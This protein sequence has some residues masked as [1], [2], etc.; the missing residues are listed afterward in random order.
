[1]KKGT[2]YIL[3]LFNAFWISI[4]SSGSKDNKATIC[5]CRKLSGVVLKMVEMAGMET[6]VTCMMVQM[7]KASS[8]GLFVVKPILKRERLL[9]VLKAWTSWDRLRTQN[10]MVL[11]TVGVPPKSKNILPMENAKRARAPIIMPSS[12]IC[13]P[14]PSEKKPFFEF[15]GFLSITS[16]SIFSTPR[17]SAGNE[18][19][20]RF[21]HNS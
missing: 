15:I 1:M 12:A 18:S 13:T 19:V 11:P 3:P 21:T 2:S 4:T 8:M 14:S 10:A 20:T 5:H 9:L 7:K 6:T 16:V 17:A